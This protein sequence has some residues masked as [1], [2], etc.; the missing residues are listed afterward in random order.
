MS[1]LLYIKANAKP[2]GVSRTFRIS[3][4]FIEAYKA[5][6]PGDEIVTLDLYKENIKPLTADDLNVIFSPKTDDSKNHPVLKYSY[7][8]AGADKYVI[9]APFWNLSI[10]GILKLYIDYVS[11]VGITFKYVAGGAVEGLLKG[12]K[13]LHIVTRGGGYSAPPLSEYEVGDRYLKAILGM[14]GMDVTTIAAENMDRSSTNV[15]EVIS[16]AIREAQ[17]KA[18]NF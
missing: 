4:S 15:E 6:N 13:A 1:K 17:D 12:K 18:R 14:F 10:P 5:N 16:N 3:D 2:E 7:Q 11:S 8:F 9:A